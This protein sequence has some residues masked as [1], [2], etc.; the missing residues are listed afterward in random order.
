MVGPDGDGPGVPLVVD[1]ARPAERG[2]EAERSQSAM[3]MAEPT[4]I[5]LAMVP[6][7]EVPDAA[8]Q[9]IAPSPRATAATVV[10][11]CARSHHLTRGAPEHGARR[12]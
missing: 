12:W 2:D 8:S 3:G 6:W 4:A 11:R 9:A 5:G 10:A 7:S 1:G